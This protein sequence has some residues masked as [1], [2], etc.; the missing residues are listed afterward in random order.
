LI[1]DQILI[2]IGE[3][4]PKNSLFLELAV[5]HAVKLTIVTQLLVQ[6]A[7]MILA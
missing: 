1:L 3:F 5:H 6:E 4:D 2:H 7:P